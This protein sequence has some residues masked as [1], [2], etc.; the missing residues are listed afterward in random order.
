M[1]TTERDT[2]LL[3]DDNPEVLQALHSLFEDDYHSLTASSGDE[4]IR[5]VQGS[6]AIAAVVMDIKM[7]GTDGIAAARAIAKLKPEL[8]IIFHTGYAGEY[9]EHEIQSQEKPFDYVEK[10]VSG[11]RLMRSVQH[12]VERRRLKC[13]VRRLQEYA[14]NSLGIIGRS[15]K[16]LEVF[17]LI[18]KVGPSNSKVMILG[19]TGTGKELVAKALHAVSPRSGKRL[20]IF[21]CN[22]KSA[23]LVESELFGHLKGAFTGAISD[24]MGLFEYADGGTVFLDEIGDLD[25]TTQAKLLRV[26]E[27]GE[28]QRVGS[29][30][31][32]TCDIRLL[33][34]THRD[35]E[36]LVKESRFR[37][38]I[39]YRLKGIQIELPPLRERPEDIPVLVERFKDQFS[40]ERDMPPKLLDSGVME[41]LTSY[42]WP[43]NVRQLLDTIE[44]LVILADSD[45]ISRVDVERY[46]RLTPTLESTDPLLVPLAERLRDFRRKCILEVLDRTD[47]NIS[48]TARILG[49]DRSNLYKD[50]KNLDIPLR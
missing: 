10:G 1:T 26:L 18:Q 34:A 33:C 35:L 27:T 38:D 47:F 45:L 5:I 11:L 4:A 32:Q 15:P 21:N 30:Q 20:A 50:I 41:V 24:R 22:H 46:L 13:D 8:A 40:V 9:D 16:M 25:I 37:M 12:A 2:I 44:S 7:P 49:M 31:V 42:A 28:F 36:G 48:E 23:D 19:E 3:V 43:G 14:E 17:K 29:P 6:P 39:F